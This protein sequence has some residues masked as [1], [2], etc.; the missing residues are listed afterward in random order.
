M[1]DLGT[2]LDTAIKTW[3]VVHTPFLPPDRVVEVLGTL[4]QRADVHGLAWGGYPQAERCRL[5]IAPIELRLEE[6]QPPLALV[7]I[8]GNFLFD[9]ATYSDFEQAIANGGLEEGD[10]GDVILLGERGAQV[11]LIPE[12]VSTLQKELKQVRTVPVTVDLCDWSELAVAPP[13]RKSLST[14]EASLRLD[15]VA[16]A[17]FGVS[18]SKMSEWISQ[19]LVRVNWQMVQQPRHLLKVNDLIAIRGKGRL[20]IQAIQVTKKERYRIQMERIR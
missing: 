11:I 2:A 3:S 4:E 8:T 12:K 15:A 1:F 18:R 13:Q 20:Q 10:Y 5:A 17:G 7:R 19:G 14:V 9:A 16:S 6:Q